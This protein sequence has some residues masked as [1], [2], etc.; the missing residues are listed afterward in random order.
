MK[1]CQTKDVV[2]PEKLA[3]SSLQDTYPSE[4][5][6]FLRTK[7][8]EKLSPWRHETGVADKDQATETQ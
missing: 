8:K 2:M 7:D 1:I 5:L 4:Q 3:S 6:L